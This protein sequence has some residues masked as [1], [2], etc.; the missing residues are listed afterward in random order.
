MEL[1]TFPRERERERE[2]ERGS[3]HPSNALPAL[4]PAT[5]AASIVRRDAHDTLMPGRS[6][7]GCL[8]NARRYMLYRDDCSGSLV[9]GQLQ[10]QEQQHK[11]SSSSSMQ[12]KEL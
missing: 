12:L 10:Q 8:I 5:A 7:A 9:A 4:L 6:T 1:P 11:K 3:H 2:R